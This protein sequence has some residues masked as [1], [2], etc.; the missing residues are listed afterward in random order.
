MTWVI[1]C[2]KF[3]VSELDLGWFY[4]ILFLLLGPHLQH[5]EVSWLGGQIGA[6]AAGHSHSSVGSEPC[7]QPIPQLVAM[8]DP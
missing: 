1:V 6:T 2:C 5:M 4:F 8:P 3:K 7:L